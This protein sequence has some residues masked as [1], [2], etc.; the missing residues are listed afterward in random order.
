MHLALSQELMEELNAY[1]VLYD[2]AGYRDSDTYPSRSVKSEAFDIQELEDKLELGTKFYIVGVSMGAYPI[3]S[4]LKYIPHRLLGAS[5]VVP[6]VNYWWHVIPSAL[7]KKPLNQLPQSFRRTFGIAHY[8]PWLYYWWT[9]Q[10]WFP[11]MVAEGM[12]TD[13]DLELLMG[14]KEDNKVNMNV[15]IETYWL[16]LENGNLIQLN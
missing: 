6:F 12:L 4:C 5:L 7:L 14:K 16:L 10:K 1:M 8:T 15:L 3:W 13:S 11:S 9:K 2:R